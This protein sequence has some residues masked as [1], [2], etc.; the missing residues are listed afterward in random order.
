MFDEVKRPK[1]KERLKIDITREIINKKLQKLNVN[2]SPGPDSL[3]PRV[4]KELATVLADPLY[5]IF[6]LSMKRSKIPTAWK[7][8]TVTAIYKNKGNRHC[9]GNYRPV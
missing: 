3:H 7:L 2:K 9:A 8:A 1:I 4:F 6:C 5:H